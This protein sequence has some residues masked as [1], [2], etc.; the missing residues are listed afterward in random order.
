MDGG[1]AGKTH[2]RKSET[3]I[4]DGGGLCS[5]LEFFSI[6]ISLVSILLS[7]Q[8]TWHISAVAIKVSIVDCIF[9]A[10][11]FIHKFLSLNNEEIC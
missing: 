6:E 8:R 7:K 1:I 9:N 2:A 4:C 11:V 3:I 10:F 5:G